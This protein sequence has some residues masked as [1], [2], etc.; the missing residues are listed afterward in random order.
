MPLSADQKSQIRQITTKI[1]VSRSENFPKDASNLRN[2]PFHQAFLTA[3]QE[4]FEGIQI[5][6]PYLL[7]LASWLHGLNT[8]LGMMYFEGVAHILSGG[9]KQ[10]FSLPVTFQQQRQA[11]DIIR[12]LNRGESQPEREREDELIMDTEVLND[13]NTNLIRFTVD[14]Y[15]EIDNVIDCVEIKTVR[16]NKGVGR[17]EKQKILLAKAAL[18]LKHREKVV[19]YYLGFPFDPT[20]NALT[21]YDKPRFIDHLIDFKKYFD[22]DEILI[23]SE[24]WD[25]LRG[26]PGSMEDLLNL[27]VE[28]VREFKSRE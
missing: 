5:E 27:V 18:K 13:P 14:N 21:G 25:H 19:R 12:K 3:F 11:G 20:S 23:A 6:T 24:L 8:S 17:D 10:T 2:A 9:R 1:L 22:P 7:A 15:R 28:T 4:R 16:P 26:Q